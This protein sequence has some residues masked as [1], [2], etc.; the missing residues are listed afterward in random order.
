MS[1]KRALAWAG[2]VA[3][4]VCGVV[5]LWDAVAMARA[6]YP[7]FVAVESGSGGIGAVS[8][9]VA[10][11]VSI[12]L[13]GLIPS[14]IVN[15]WLARRARAA[16]GRLRSLHR[17]HSMLLA[18]V[19]VGVVLLVL[20]IAVGPFLSIPALFGVELLALFAIGVQ[21]LVLAGILAVIA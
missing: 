20:A 19:A 21:F 15:R 14:V 7:L 2:A 10:S 1:F 17:V 12:A 5:I 18:A 9:G 8:V 13:L 11:Q 4:A 16:Q 6:F 3:A